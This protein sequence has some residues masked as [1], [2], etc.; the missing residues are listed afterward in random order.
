MP[1]PR[2]H[3]A[4]YACDLHFPQPPLLPKLRMAQASCA[5]SPDHT[6]PDHGL[7]PVSFAPSL[8]N[9]PRMRPQT[10][11]QPTASRMRKR[12]FSPDARAKRRQG[13]YGWE[14]EARNDKNAWLSWLAVCPAEGPLKAEVERQ[15]RVPRPAHA[16]SAWATQTPQTPP[17]FRIATPAASHALARSRPTPRISCEAVPRPTRRRGAQG[18]TQRRSHGLP[19]LS[20][21]QLHPLV[22]GLAIRGDRG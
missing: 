14:H 20:V 3:P 9:T 13:D 10:T 11:S 17:R 21:R 4:W 5:I 22:G 2:D 8:R 16:Q 6:R 1:A 15:G 18:G 19:P 7:E 12:P